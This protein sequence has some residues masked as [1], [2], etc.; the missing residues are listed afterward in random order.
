MV[1]ESPTIEILAVD[2]SSQDPLGVPI[3]ILVLVLAVVLLA[4]FGPEEPAF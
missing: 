1:Y 3:L 2:R 4:V